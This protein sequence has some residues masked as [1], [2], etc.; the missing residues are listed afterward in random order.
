MTNG[1]PSDRIL[2]EYSL[3]R[4]G[5]TAEVVTHID[6]CAT[7][8]A[9]VAAY[10]QLFTEVN[11][12]PRPAFEFDTASLVLSQLPAARPGLSKGRGLVFLLALLI[13][14]VIGIPLYLLRR[15]IFYL[16][17][18]VSAFFLYMMAG[19]TLVVLFFKIHSMYRK[20]H[21][22]LDALNYY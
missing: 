15:N 18:D 1:H 14:P 16:F 7:C 19:A 13:T 17:T 6:A 9:H 10:R 21:R 2:Q 3:D 4:S 12:L 11:R 5:V 22:Q 20:Y 8:Q